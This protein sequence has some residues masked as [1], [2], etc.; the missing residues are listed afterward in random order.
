MEMIPYYLNP[1]L[2]QVETCSHAAGECNSETGISGYLSRYINEDFKWI[3]AQCLFNR[4]ADLND[5]VGY[6]YG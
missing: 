4:A 1:T 6:V 5:L 2:S 3:G